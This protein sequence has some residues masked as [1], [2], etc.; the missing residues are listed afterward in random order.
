MRIGDASFT[1]V[2]EGSGAVALE[3]EL[4]AG[5]TDVL[6]DALETRRG[7]GALTLDVARLEFMDSSGV[8]ALLRASGAVPGRCLIV[9]GAHGSVAKVLALTHVGEAPQIHV[10]PCDR[11][12]VVRID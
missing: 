7:E 4:D 3:G 2:D 11:H 6:R 10:V 9:H 1:V 5:S 8:H 12:D